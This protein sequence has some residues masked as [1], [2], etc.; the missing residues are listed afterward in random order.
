MK[1]APTLLFF[2]LCTTGC[3]ALFA[4]RNTENPVITAT[5]LGTLTPRF[6]WHGC[7]GMAS[8]LTVTDINS[9][10]TQSYT[11]SSGASFQVNER[12]LR[13]MASYVAE[14]SCHDGRRSNPISFATAPVDWSG[15][16]WI[17]GTEQYANLLRHSFRVDA[18]QNV[19]V[20]IA[21]AGYYEAYVN[22]AHLT[23]DTVLDPGVTNFTTRIFSVTYPN[24]ELNAGENVIGLV[25]GNN[26]YGMEQVQYKAQPHARVMV[27]DT[28]GH[29]VASSSSAWMCMTGPNVMNNVY[30]GETFDS[31]KSIP[32]WHLPG[33]D[34]KSWKNVSLVQSFDPRIS[35]R[36]APPIKVN[37]TLKAV[38]MTN[39]RPGIWVFDF[40][41]T[42][43][44]FCSV[45]NLN[46]PAGSNLTM[47]YGEI[48]DHYNKG[49]SDLVYFGNLRS[50]KA[51]DT[52]ILSGTGNEEY[53][54]EFTYHG[55]RFM[56]IEAFPPGQTPKIDDFVA[57]EFYTAVTRVGT[58]HSS[59]GI[60][61]RIHENTVFGQANNLMS[62]PT[63]CNQR[64][65]RLGWSADAW[66][67][68]DEAV[69]NYDM[70]D[71]GL[72]YIDLINDDQ[73]AGGEVA[74]VIPHF[75]FGGMPADPSWGIVFPMIVNSTMTS[76]ND[77]DMA[78]KQLE[79]IRKWTDYLLH[80]AQ[81]SGLGNMYASYGDWVVPPGQPKVPNSMSSAWAVVKAVECVINVARVT[82][83]TS[84]ESSYTAI[85]LNLVQDF[86]NT[87][88]NTTSGNYGESQTADLYALDVGVAPASTIKSLLKKLQDVNF[89]VGS[90]I[91]GIW[92]LFPFLRSAQLTNVALEILAQTTMPSYGWMFLNTIETP[93]TT[94]WELWDSPLEGDGMNS[95]DHIMFGSVDRFLY[96][97]AGI[98]RSATHSVSIPAT[99]NTILRHAAAS[100]ML[101]E[102][103][104]AVEW[105][106]TGGRLCVHETEPAALVL[107]CD[108][109]AIEEI[110]FV[111]VGNP[112]GT[113][114]TYHAQD[115]C[116]AKIDLNMCVGTHRCV[117]PHWWN[118]SNTDNCGEPLARI[119]VRAR[120]AAPHALD[121]V[122]KTPKHVEVRLPDVHP[123]RAMRIN[124][125]ETAVAADSTKPVFLVGPGEHRWRVTGDRA[126]EVKASIDSSNLNVRCPTSTMHILEVSRVEAHA[127]Q[128]YVAIHEVDS[129]CAGRSECHV[130][131]KSLGLSHACLD[132]MTLFVH[133]A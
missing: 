27:V 87:F 42:I 120:C 78:A 81:E 71:F 33:F 69:L 127:C 23:R 20:H 122:V 125:P 64:D 18:T 12:D 44:G 45:K 39:P 10:Q 14:V 47:R 85:R 41:R 84:M 121:V 130:P 36:F 1:I 89:H 4:H 129:L 50:A 91:L 52:Y 74:D 25:L 103:P 67:S 57:L 6:K 131:L 28:N 126:V 58:F 108:G 13:P 88:F 123:L 22:K 55:F 7:D 97:L 56:Q 46:G 70:H 11:L 76:Y 51:T 100:T 34:D 8:T 96:S 133:C 101:P 95:R 15:S 38:S 3:H 118:A 16:S 17:Q 30:D 68:F 31:R 115:A 5:R 53:T 106:R 24:V 102:G 43:S 110:E 114:T 59:N 109:S 48:M 77:K 128:T 60:L 107:D 105:R 83:N 21:V 62:M 86:N 26:F 80:R 35:P 66:L 117:V 94:L 124:A 54:P 32:G 79:G 61:N 116:H 90:G 9:K 104:I 119:S 99:H 98:D 19:T 40:G 92:V 113:C 63:D 2:V 72:S 75:R 132:S 37:S 82:G 29:M 93:A 49:Q 111:S 112:L 65:E 73:L